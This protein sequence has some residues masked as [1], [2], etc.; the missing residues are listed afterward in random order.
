M[1]V[2]WS[3][4]AERDLTALGDR[5]A[6]DDPRLA[7]EIGGEIFTAVERLADLPHRGRPGRVEGTRELVLAPLP[8]IAVYRVDGVAVTILRVLHGARDWPPGEAP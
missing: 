4:E 8:W 5:I 7:A 1:I 2:I 6:P 3:S